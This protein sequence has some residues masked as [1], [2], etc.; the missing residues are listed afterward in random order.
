MTISITLFML[1]QILYKSYYL[2][3]TDQHVPSNTKTQ[4]VI[5]P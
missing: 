5:Y 3:T 2:G 1:N 4:S